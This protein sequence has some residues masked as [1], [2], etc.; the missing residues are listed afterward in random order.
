L[1]K[2]KKT[3]YSEKTIWDDN[4]TIFDDNKTVWD[5]NKTIFDDNK[6]KRQ[7]HG[8]TS[9]SIKLTFL[10]KFTFLNSGL[11]LATLLL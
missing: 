4:K 3:R 8:N 11:V 5:D 7:F 2:S 6:R 1:K 9:P 10:Q